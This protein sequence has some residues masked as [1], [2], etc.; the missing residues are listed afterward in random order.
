VADKHQPQFVAF[1]QYMQGTIS[2][3]APEDRRHYPEAAP[4]TAA[5]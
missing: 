4:A 3:S 2:V 5:D 1:Q